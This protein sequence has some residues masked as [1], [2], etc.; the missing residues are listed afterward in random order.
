MKTISDKIQETITLAR[1]KLLKIPAENARRK[2][3][4]DTWSQQEVLGHL[5]DSALINHQR[6]VRGAFNLAGNFPGYEQ[7]RWVEFQ[8]YNTRNWPDL[9]EFWFQVNLHL[10][11]ALDALPPEALTNPCNIGKETP[12]PLSFVIE[13]YLRHLQMHLEQILG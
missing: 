12:L 11:R 4:R 13:D 3:D 8:A 9:I 1:P 5:I 6:F 10:C 7:N 2:A